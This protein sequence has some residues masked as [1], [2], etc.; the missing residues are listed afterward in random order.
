MNSTYKRLVSIKSRLPYKILNQNDL[1]FFERNVKTLLEKDDLSGYNQDWMG[2]YNG[3]SKVVLKPKDS[4]QLSKILKYCND[5]NIA[6][7]PQVFKEL[8]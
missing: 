3:N 8:N 6:V 1:Q 5:E 7:V 4:L 2:K